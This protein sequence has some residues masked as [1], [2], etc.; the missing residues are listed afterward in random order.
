MMMNGVGK[1][2]WRRRL[3]FT[4]L[5]SVDVHHAFLHQCQHQ[6]P[7]RHASVKSILTIT[8]PVGDNYERDSIKLRQMG[9]DY[10]S[11]LSATDDDS[12]DKD[13]STIQISTTPLNSVESV[14]KSATTSVSSE[15][16][17]TA[18]GIKSITRS[19]SSG[20]GSVTSK[21]TNDIKSITRS[22]SSGIGSVTAKGTNEL[23]TITRSVSSGIGSVA[24]MGASSLT[25]EVEKR[26]SDI[27]S[28][29]R[30]ASSGLESVAKK[31]AKDFRITTLVA[32]RAVKKGTKDVI[33]VAGRGVEETGNLAIGLAERTVSDTGKVATWI[34]SQA[35]AGTEAVTSSTKRAVLNFTGKSSYEF[36]DVSKETVRRIAAGE[37][38]MQDFILLL[39]ILLAVGATIGPLAELLPFTF[40]LEALNIS[41]EQKVGGKVMEVLAKSLDSRIV[42]ALF[43]SDDKNLIG[44]VAKRSLLSGILSYTGKPNYESGDIQRAVLQHENEDHSEEKTLDIDVSEFAEWDNVFIE[45]LGAELDEAANIDPEELNTAKEMD[46]KIALALEG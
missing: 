4:I 36:G 37:V 12:Q 40:L 20:I 21:G 15:V 32:G 35:K 44:D 34:D 22:V 16:G 8:F 2:H 18:N 43:T 19:V 13:T 46:M 42:G 3:T 11:N 24:K 9:N 14:L 39:K 31:G 10:L 38:N 33:N 17:K 1:W 7:L 27:Q 5:L 28:V 25:S 45:K 30:T 26:T 23:K 29:A 6:Q 41:I